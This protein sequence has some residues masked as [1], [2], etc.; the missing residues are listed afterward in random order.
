VTCPAALA[1]GPVCCPQGQVCQDIS[2]GTCA[3][4]TPGCIPDTFEQACTAA[5]LNCGPVSDGCGGEI[6]CGTCHSTKKK[7]RV[8]SANVC[9]AK[10][11]KRCVGSG[12]AGQPCSG[13]KC[14]CRGGRRCH[15]GKCCEPVGDGSVHCNANSDCCPGL[16]CAR[17]R[18]GQHKVCMSKTAKDDFG[19]TGETAVATPSL[20]LGAIL[21]G[22]AV[23]SGS[24][25]FG[26]AGENAPIAL[27]ELSN[28][29]ERQE[30]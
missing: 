15:N 10:G 28:R 27:D 16:M 7:K 8:C 26:S 25:L 14:K 13:K 18:P 5:G 1:C 4:P 30:I 3:P 19:T 20:A 6:D 21:T 12:L 2:T 9:R 22:L 24:R 23:K 11:G 17:R 29:D